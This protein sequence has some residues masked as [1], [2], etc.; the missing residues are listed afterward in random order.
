M[1]STTEHPAVSK[2]SISAETAPLDT[3]NVTGL[4]DHPPAQGTPQNSIYFACVVLAM[5]AF[6]TIANGLLLF[7]LAYFKKNR[8][9]ST[10]KLILNQAAL[11]LLSCISLAINYALQIDKR[12]FA[13]DIGSYVFCLLLD[14]GILYAMGLNGSIAAWC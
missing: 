10:N 8:E 12:V 4:P 3:N 13:N 6:G 2:I 14:G 5:G 7:V 9:Q 11:D 1:A